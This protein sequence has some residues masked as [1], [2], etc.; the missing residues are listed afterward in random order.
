MKMAGKRSRSTAQNGDPRSRTGVRS[1]PKSAAVAAK[2]QGSKG[3]EKADA[4]A[5][6]RKRG[7]GRARGRVWRKLA[8]AMRARILVLERMRWS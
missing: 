8:P 1:E 3:H 5:A 7:R 6:H 4:P 2:S